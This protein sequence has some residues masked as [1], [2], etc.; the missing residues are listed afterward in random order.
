[1]SNK[2]TGTI[3]Q[4]IGAVLD[5]RFSPDSLPNLLIDIDM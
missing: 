2:N 4:V 1:M 3:V 5:I